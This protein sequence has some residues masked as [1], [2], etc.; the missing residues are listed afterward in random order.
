[1]LIFD[2]EMFKQTFV[3]LIFLLCLFM[4]IFSLIY[5]SFSRSHLG[6]AT[7]LRFSV[8]EGQGEH[9]ASTGVIRRA[10][11]GR[12]VALRDEPTK[13]IHPSIYFRAKSR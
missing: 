3:N 6:S 11:K 12:M 2:V 9:F 10:Q 13:V 4:R 8:V 5:V 7:D 1:M